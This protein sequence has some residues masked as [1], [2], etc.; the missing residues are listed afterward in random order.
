MYDASLWIT[1]VMRRR[2]LL[3][4]ASR[5]PGFLSPSQ[6]GVGG[7]GQSEESVGVGCCGD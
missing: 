5:F 2:W 1:E 4:D 3:Y 6:Y 7:V